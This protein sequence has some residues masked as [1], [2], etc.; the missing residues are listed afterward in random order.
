MSSA[1]E[2]PLP[3]AAGNL[4]VKVAVR[5]CAPSQVHTE[6]S[7]DDHVY[8]GDT[9]HGMSVSVAVNER[10][11]LALEGFHF[12]GDIESVGFHSTNSKGQNSLSSPESEDHTPS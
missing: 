11:A 8:D 5:S 3:Y 12:R 1:R 6:L 7:A 10:T 2:T 4:Q 9:N